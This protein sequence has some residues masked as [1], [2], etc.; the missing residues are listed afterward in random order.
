MRTSEAVLHL[1]VK[2]PVKVH[3]LSEHVLIKMTGSIDLFP[4]AT[5]ALVRMQVECK[6]LGE[7]ICTGEDTKLKREAMRAQTDI[8]W[9]LL[10][11]LLF[12]VNKA[13]RGDKVIIFSSGFECRKETALL[14]DV[15]AKPV[16]RRVSDGRSAC[17]VKVYMAAVPYADRYKLEIATDASNPVWVT[18][19]DFANLNEL[20][21][22]NQERG[23]ELLVRVIAGNSRGWS[24]P[25]DPVS[26]IPR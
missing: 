7:L 26:F 25:S 22:K 1:R 16:I 12:Y 14:T 18:C 9:N 23:R 3:Y 13:A 5:D 6:K 4:D 11:E 21:A 17:S 20:E 2:E 8:V 10:R 15:P 24:D 19:I